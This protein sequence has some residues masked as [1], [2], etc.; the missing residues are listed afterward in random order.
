MLDK[1]GRLIK[2]RHRPTIKARK[3]LKYIGPG[4][5]VTVGFIDPGNWA[6]N[7]AAG[8]ELLVTLFLW[9]ITISTAMLDIFTT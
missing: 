5:L 3:F 4:V 2:E 7:I 9:V 1:L 6:A 8:S